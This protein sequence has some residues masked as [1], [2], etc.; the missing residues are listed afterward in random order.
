M[1]KHLV[2][3]FLNCSEKLLQSF[4]LERQRRMWMGLRTKKR[5]DTAGNGNE[6]LCVCVWRWWVW[7][8]GWKIVFNHFVRITN[9]LRVCLPP[10][11][12]IL[13]RLWSIAFPFHPFLLT[14][15]PTSHAILILYVC[16]E[17]L[18]TFYAM[19]MMWWVFILRGCWL[20]PEHFIYFNTFPLNTISRNWT[21]TRGCRPRVVGVV[22]WTK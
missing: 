16:L 6:V 17:K 7:I 1:T 2:R 13:F 15:S 12:L 11:I 3:H 19:I 10:H 20:L 9:S 18:W 4:S 22:D 14:L 8:C 5:Q 21:G